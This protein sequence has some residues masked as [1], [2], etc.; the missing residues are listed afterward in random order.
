MGQPGYLTFAERI[1]VALAR[2]MHGIMHSPAYRWLHR[3]GMRGRPFVIAV[4]Y[5]WLLLF[6]V[7]PFLIVLKIAFAKTVLGIPPYSPLLEW[8]GEQAV[9]VNLNLANFTFLLRDT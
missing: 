2:V 3:H 9:T 6:F 7:V 1:S 4:P 5:L 8:I